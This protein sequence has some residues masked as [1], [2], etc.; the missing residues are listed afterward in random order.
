MS[1]TRFSFSWKSIPLISVV[2]VAL[3]IFLLIW[4]GT[5]ISDKILNDANTYGASLADSYAEEDNN[6]FG[7]YEY[8]LE[9]AANYLNSYIEDDNTDSSTINTWL[10]VYSTNATEVLEKSNNASYA[11]IDL[12][13]VINDSIVAATPWEGDSSYDFHSTRWYNDALNSPEGLVYSDSYIDSLSGK[14][15]ITLSVKLSGTNNV[16]A[17]DIPTDAISAHKEIATL[18]KGSSYYLFDNKGN[19][20]YQVNDTT[21]EID[22]ST[23]QDSRISSPSSKPSSIDTQNN[24]DTAYLDDLLALSHDPTD[25]QT[26]TIT[27]D[28]GET[29]N[30]YH[31]HLANG[32][33]VVITQPTDQILQS[34]WNTTLI[35]LV[36]ISFALFIVVIIVVIRVQYEAHKTI[37]VSDTLAILGDTFYAIYRIN[38]EKGTYEVVKPSPGLEKQLGR[39]GKYDHLMNVIGQIIEKDAYEDLVE[40]FKLENIQKIIKEGTTEYGG[41]FLR[42]FG[43]TYKWVSVKAIYNN[44]LDLN[45]VIL[46]FREIDA[47]KR[48]QI[49]QMTLLENALDSAKQSGEKKEIFFSNVSHDMRTPLNAIIGL[50]DLAQQNRLNTEKLNEYLSGIKN[51]SDQLLILINDI[52]DITRAESETNPSLNYLPMDL[53][54]TVQDS[55]LLFADRAKKENKTIQTKYDVDEPFV[56]CDPYRI[57]QIMNNLL[58][59]ALKY[60]LDGA[61][62]TVRVS[63]LSQRGKMRKYQIEVRDTGIGMSQEFLNEIFEPFARETR[64]ASKPISGTGLGMPIVKSLV[65]QMSGEI[66]VQSSL[67]VGSVF[68]I[69]LPLV[70]VEGDND[71]VKPLLEKDEVPLD[72]SGKT[73][74]LAEDN[75]INLLITE[76]LLKSLG[77]TILEARNGKEALDIFSS[78]ETGSIDVILMDMQMPVMDGC[79]ASKAIRALNRSDAK[80]IPIFTVTANAFAEDVSRTTE[81]GMNDHLSKPIDKQSLENALRRLL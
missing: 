71:L 44:K 38:F 15:I 35:P 54:Q 9:S 64:F 58:S 67:G 28:F 36:I 24:S 45:E 34:D 49:Q 16:L 23:S 65:Q 46:C 29:L 53:V 59:N 25:I 57:Q 60:S 27:T 56:L 19:L 79:E 14:E 70:V 43:D 21:E 13:G 63:I 3:F 41:D 37:H 61:R 42:K 7:T 51:A 17:L 8:A 48:K 78:L 12:Y 50:C 73:V 33:T 55:V 76:E 30:V 81:A 39:H 47:E 66:N 74:L 26:A 62:I 20:L 18:G 22:S 52:L 72:L 69:T 68:T 6:Y 1:Q 32:W 10:K 2:L 4:G 11:P 5:L 75:E 31:S 77:P 80:T 40:S